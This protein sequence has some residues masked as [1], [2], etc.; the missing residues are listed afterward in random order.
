MC[1]VCK[2]GGGGQGSPEILH[3]DRHNN[4]K[5]LTGNIKTLCYGCVRKLKHL[6]YSP[7]T[8]FSRS[9]STY[10]LAAMNEDF[11]NVNWW[12]IDVLRNVNTALKLFNNIVKDTFDLHAP[13]IVRKVR[14]ETG[15]WLNSDLRKLMIDRDR[16]LRKARN[17]K[18]EMHWSLYKKLRN[19]CNNKLRF[20]NCF[21]NL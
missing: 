13:E 12:P 15:P 17:T 16:M 19:S 21:D 18:E 7:R 20:A 8:V 1:N 10:D 5:P 11:K 2:G 9:Y 6:K 14:G 4:D 3:F